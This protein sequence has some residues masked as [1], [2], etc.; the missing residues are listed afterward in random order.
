MNKE[1]MIQKLTGTAPKPVMIVE[2]QSVDDIITALVMKHEQCRSDYDK[3]ASEFEHGT[4]LDICKNLWTFCKKNFNYKIEDEDNQYTSC[5][6]T[7][8][9]NGKV[10][11]KNYSLFISGILDALKR[12]GYKLNWKYRF[13]CYR[14]FD[15]Q[16]KVLLPIEHVFVV[17]NENTDNIWIDPVFDNF[18]EHAFYLRKKD[19]TPKR[20]GAIGYVNQARA[21]GRQ[22]NQLSEE[23]KKYELGLVQAV[24]LSQSTG[25][26]NTITQ[27]VLKTASYAFP[28]AAAALAV[29]KLAGGV[30]NNAFGVGSEAARIVNDIGNLNFGALFSDI[31]Q[32]RTYG[33]GSYECAVYYQ[34]YVLGKQVYDTRKIA[35]SDVAPA[36]NWFIDRTGVFIQDA[37]HIWALCESPEKY[38]S[39]ALDTS[40]ETSGYITTDYKRVAAASQVARKY[41]ASA[42]EGN[43]V[44]DS[45]FTGA[46]ANTVGV[47]DNGLVQLANRLGKTAEQFVAQTGIN[48]VDNPSGIPTG[49]QVIPGVDN[50]WLYAGL[51]GLVLFSLLKEN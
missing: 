20:V 31:F 49:S 33:A 1:V 44:Y 29:I 51:G 2:R 5:P 39:M 21:I 45:R 3:I 17:V 16:T 32:G 14:V 46:W 25:T 10:D 12:R 37:V 47:F 23:L 35:D 34:N 50:I 8:L 43:G 38:I 41:W 27:S 40:Q 4:L 26:F 22:I 11:C 42:S 6:Y 7:I 28:P 9:T 15:P 19:R 18:N 36:L 24:Q 13:A 30:L 48:Y